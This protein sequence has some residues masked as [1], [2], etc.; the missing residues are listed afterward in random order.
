MKKYIL[1]IIL[2]TLIF[3]CK[4]DLSGH[5]HA[6]AKDTI[7]TFEFSMDINKNGN[8]YLIS[9]LHYNPIKG[10]HT[11]NENTIFFPAECGVLAF[12]YIIITNTLYLENDLGTILTAKKT[13]CNR[14]HDYKTKLAID[15]LK[16]KKLKKDSILNDNSLNNYIN[17]GFSKKDNTIAV[18]TNTS[19]EIQKINSLDSLIYKIKPNYS[20]EEFPF[21]NYILTPDKNIKAKDFYKIL[22]K[23]NKN[24]EKNIFIRTLKDSFS[25][26]D[27]DI[28][29][30]IRIKKGRFDFNSD[31]TL[32]EII[33]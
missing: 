31:K 16:L 20:D 17:I 27:R 24:G 14:I 11:P 25:S 29:E 23:L 7:R 30:F 28:F 3:S 13:T 19:S 1:L 10:K 9:H 8:S 2:T 6:K 21:I 5:W 12:K 15:F 4:R 22:E 33:N 18:E 32:K 26:T